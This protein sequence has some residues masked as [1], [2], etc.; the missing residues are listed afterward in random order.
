MCAPL[1]WGSLIFRGS[2]AFLPQSLGSPSICALKVPEHH[3]RVLPEDSD[4]A[5][6]PHTLSTCLQCTP[7]PARAG[8][9]PG[10]LALAQVCALAS[11][12]SLHQLG[13]KDRA[14]CALEEASSPDP[15][16]T[17]GGVKG[18]LN[19][20]APTTP[21]PQPSRLS[22]LTLPWDPQ[23]D[24]RFLS[25]HRKPGAPASTA[26][27]LSYLSSA[28]L[29]SSLLPP[30]AGISCLWG[31]FPHPSQNMSSYRTERDN[32]LPCWWPHPQLLARPRA[33]MTQY[34]PSK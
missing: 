7:P 15:Y 17:L 20:G 8:S 1:S 31:P 11:P 3:P 16:I 30:L 28:F 12:H 21:L 6:S 32:F 25:D 22:H 10:A 18:P 9:Q 4:R 2:H 14:P 13:Q 19:L 24:P 29:V 33:H 34:F 23:E 26:L 27:T 5:S